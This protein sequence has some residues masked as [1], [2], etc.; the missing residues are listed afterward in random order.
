MVNAFA[1]WPCQRHAMPTLKFT[2]LRTHIQHG[3]VSTI[4]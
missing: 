3:V 1:L 2:V 4:Q